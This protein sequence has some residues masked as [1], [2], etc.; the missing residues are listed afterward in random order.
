MANMLVC[1]LCGREIVRGGN[2]TDAVALSVRK[3]NT[4]SVTPNKVWDF[5]PNCY[6][7]LVKYIDDT[8]HKSMV[9]KDVT[10]DYGASKEDK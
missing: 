9:F 6:S 2:Y 10:T 7:G 8:R 5:H 4:I 1:D 3:L